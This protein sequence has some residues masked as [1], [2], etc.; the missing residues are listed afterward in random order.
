M[1]AE[2]MVLD[3]GAA[4]AVAYW[5]RAGTL[6]NRKLGVKEKGFRTLPMPHL[7]TALRASIAASEAG[8]SFAVLRFSGA[9]DG[10]T[11]WRYRLEGVEVGRLKSKGALGREAEVRTYP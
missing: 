4:P 9:Q 2:L 1:P 5:R 7:V 3:A 10:G 8:R 6:E 11:R